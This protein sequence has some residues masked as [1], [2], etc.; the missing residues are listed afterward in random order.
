[1]YCNQCRLEIPDNYKFCPKCGSEVT[2][3]NKVIENKKEELKKRLSSGEISGKEYDKL[4]KKIE[5]EEKSSVKSSKKK[6]GIKKKAKITIGIILGIFVSLMI[7]GAVTMSHEG[8]S[9]QNWAGYVAESGLYNPQPLVTMVSASWKVVPIPPDTSG[10]VKDMVQWIGIGGSHGSD[11]SLIQVGTESELSDTFRYKAWYELYPDNVAVPLM[12]VNPGDIV[13]AKITCQSSC[14]SSTQKWIINFVDKTTGKQSP[15]IN[16]SFSSR[17][18]T[19]D[20][21]IERQCPSNVLSSCELASILPNFGTATFSSAF[22][23]IGNTTGHINTFKY[24]SMNMTA[25]G[26]DG[27]ALLAYPSSLSDDGSSFT[28]IRG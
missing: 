24:V 13:N 9:S 5:K 14:D 10:E 4:L 17:M 20:W 16:T 26:Q 2:W 6:M 27:G 7:V 21:V 23:T 28:I 25:N 11:D 19:A 8:T 12:A 1:M 3:E 22:V 15:P 18:L